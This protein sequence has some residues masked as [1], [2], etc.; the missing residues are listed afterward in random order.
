MLLKEVYEVNTRLHDTRAYY[1]L[2]NYRY[3]MVITITFPSTH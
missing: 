2:S 1:R 3:A